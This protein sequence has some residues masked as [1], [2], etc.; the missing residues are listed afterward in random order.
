M[1]ENKRGGGRDSF[2]FMISLRRYTLKILRSINNARDVVCQR[3]EV[4]NSLG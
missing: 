2:L 4:G 1:R 3:D